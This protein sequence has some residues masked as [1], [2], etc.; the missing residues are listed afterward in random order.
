MVSRFHGRQDTTGPKAGRKN[1]GVM[2]TDREV[3]RIEADERNARTPHIRTRAHRE[4]RCVPAN[5]AC[6]DT[7]AAPA[8]NR[9]QTLQRKLKAAREQH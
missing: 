1:K 9:R 2:R 8:W 6:L 5:N 7:H 4:G 3:K